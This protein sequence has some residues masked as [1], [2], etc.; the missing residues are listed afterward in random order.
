MVEVNGRQL[1]TRGIVLATG[2]GPLVPPLPGLEDVGYLTSDTLWSLDT[3]PRRLLVLGGGPIGCELAQAFARLG[4]AVTVVEMAPRLLPREDPAVG[5]LLQHVFAAEGIALELHV[6]AEGFERVEGEGR[7]HLRSLALGDAEPHVL[8][9]DTLL[10]A[11]G[12]R[13]R[14]EGF[15]L[16]ELG[17]GR[18]PAGTLETD[19]WLGTELPGV[20]ACGDVVGPRQFTHAASHQAWYATVNALFGDFR[21]FALDDRVMP[22]CTFTDPE[23]A[24]VG[25]S[26]EEARSRGLAVEVTTVDLAHNDRAVADGAERGFVKVL[27]PPGNDRILGVTLVGEHA[28]DLIAPFVLA[29]KHNLGLNHIL[30]TVHIYPTLAEVNRQAAAAW[31]RRQVKPWQL[32]LLEKFHAW[33]RGD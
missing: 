14:I 16:E 9:F 13:A 5:E 11:L 32:D 18:G 8:A 21:R 3:L 19:R 15:G 29:M 17:L 6:R 2:A 10:V 26:E 20:H 33:R 1:T 31:R 27:T 22:W 25:L 24:R 28:G 4:S 30:G 23:V 12:R 7:V